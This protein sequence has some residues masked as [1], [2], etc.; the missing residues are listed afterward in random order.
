MEIDLPNTISMTSLSSLPGVLMRRTCASL[1]AC[2]SNER[3]VWPLTSIPRAW[4]V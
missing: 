4:Y 3:D 2:T 1:Q